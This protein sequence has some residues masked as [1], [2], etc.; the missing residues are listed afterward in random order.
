MLR[1]GSHHPHLILIRAAPLGTKQ[2]PRTQKSQIVHSAIA[3]RS[4]ESFQST[5]SASASA[6]RVQHHPISVTCVCALIAAFTF[7]PV[8]V[9][10]R[11][12]S[13]KA[14][15]RRTTGIRQRSSAWWTQSPA[16]ASKAQRSIDRTSAVSGSTST[17][18]DR[19][20]VDLNKEHART[21]TGMQHG[22]MPKRSSEWR[23]WKHLW[24]S[25][26]G[27]S[28]QQAAYESTMLPAGFNPTAEARNGHALPSTS[29][30]DSTRIQHKQANVLQQQQG[31]LKPQ[32]VEHHDRE[33]NFHP[34][35]DP[36]ETSLRET[37]K[38]RKSESASVAKYEQSEESYQGGSNATRS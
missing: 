13:N 37:P 36:G 4:V 30:S 2:R 17:R 6:A 18:T 11:W 15:E 35:A 7:L 19:T 1:G 3:K 14:N 5:P 29:T 32:A 26:T 9:F 24:L 28:F 10:Q 25:S 12:G 8:L 20:A 38:Q 27:A 21:G 33:R 31:G 23:R 22:R 34:S 16:S